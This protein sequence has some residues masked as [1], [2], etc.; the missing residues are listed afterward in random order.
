MGKANHLEPIHTGGPTHIMTRR[1]PAENKAATRVGNGRRTAI[2]RAANLELTGRTPVLFVAASTGLVQM[3]HSHESSWQNHDQV[4]PAWHES[5][6]TPGAPRNTSV[7]KFSTA[8]G[9]VSSGQVC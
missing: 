5:Q 6:I 2:L 9:V 1:E 7:P 4:L 8:K 3:G